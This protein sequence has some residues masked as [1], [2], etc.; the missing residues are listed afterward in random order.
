VA[1][2]ILQGVV[3][4][5]LRSVELASA[6]E[7][8]LRR[9]VSSRD[10]YARALLHAERRE[11]AR[12]AAELHDDA[13]Q[14]LLAARQDLAEARRGQPELLVTAEGRLASGIDRLRSM[15][16]VRAPGEPPMDIAGLLDRVLAPARARGVGVRV[17]V[18]K[19]DLARQPDA[20]EI[21][22]ELVS[23]A[24]KHA[25]ARA[26]D[27]GVRH[28]DGDLVLWVRDDGRG[29]PAGRLREARTEGHVG[30][31]LVEW[32]VD[33]LGGQVEIESAPGRGVTAT[34]R[35]PDLRR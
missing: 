8:D 2:A 28:D 21:L 31:A 19:D 18:G 23:N 14:T 25:N 10:R 11:R 12:V 24:V 1:L 20:V 16:T 6:R 29:F 3:Q 27:V 33:E 9:V 7:R 13:L 34:V 26:I 17:S 32:R 4:A 15:L 35:L 30:L 22:V 5:V